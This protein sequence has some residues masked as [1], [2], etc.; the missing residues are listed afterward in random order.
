MSAAVSYERVRE[1]LDALSMEAALDALDVVLEAGQKQE[2]TTVE[3]IDELL[4]RERDDRFQRR[5]RTNLRLSGISTPKTLE[6]FDF[7]AQPQAPKKTIDE[8]STLRFLHQ[9]ENVLF[10]GPPGVGKS[11]LALGLSLKALEAGHRVYFLTLHD[12]VA[13]ARA[14][15]SKSR[16]DTFQNTLVRPDL[17]VIDEV[18]YLP[19]EQHD[20]TFLF[21]VVSKRYERLKPI[22]LTSNKTYASW[23]DFFPDSVLATALLDR[24]LHH[25]TT[26]SIRGESYRLRHRRLAGL[27][28]ENKPEK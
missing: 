17:L 5:I 7:E 25:A 20:A 11:H 8:L 16:L 3:V 15:R 19:L 13:K 14:A 10:L 27:T 21:E 12:L 24:L 1:H 23:G 9:G 28:P 18:G 22:I 26:I 4:T 6:A 2:R